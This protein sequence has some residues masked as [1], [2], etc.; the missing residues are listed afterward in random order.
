MKIHQTANLTAGILFTLILG[1]LLHFCY[2]WSGHNPFAALF[3]PINES[4]WEHLKMLFFPALIY[5]LFEVFVLSKTSARFLS[6]RTLGMVL[7]MFFIVSS[8]YTCT[9][10]TGKHSLAMDI[11]IF[12]LAVLAAFLLSRCLEVH[13]PAVCL[14]SWLSSAILLLIVLCFFIFTARLHSR[15]SRIRPDKPGAVSATNHWHF[16]TLYGMLKNNCGSAKPLPSL[17]NGIRAPVKR[18]YRKCIKSSRRP[19]LSGREL[20]K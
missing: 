16:P 3:L 5:T 9:G 12:I 4:V 11:L 18:G 8:F 20:Y 7:G 17:V 1:T 13:C 2:D 6:A 14:P 19:V 10:I 15:S